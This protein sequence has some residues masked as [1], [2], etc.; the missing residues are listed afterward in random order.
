MTNIKMIEDEMY[1]NL[2]K[3]YIFRKVPMAFLFVK[4]EDF[5]SKAIIEEIEKLD[6]PFN[7]YIVDIDKCPKTADEYHVCDKNEYWKHS[8]DSVVS[9]DQ[10]PILVMNYD[11]KGEREKEIR[12]FIHMLNKYKLMIT[13]SK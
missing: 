6:F 5:I 4:S 8:S 10:F 12:N 7:V 9:Y 3:D 1:D 11:G 2:E 13:S